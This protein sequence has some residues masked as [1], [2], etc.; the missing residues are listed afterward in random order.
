MLWEQDY[1]GSLFAGEGAFK[2]NEAALSAE[3]IDKIER[4]LL[5]CLSAYGAFR[6]RDRYAEVFGGTLGQA[7]ETHLRAAWRRLYIGNIT[8]TDPKGM[9]LVEKVIQ[10]A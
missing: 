2:A 8:K 1:A 10:P 3:W 4:N 7:R 5:Y 9:R 6:I